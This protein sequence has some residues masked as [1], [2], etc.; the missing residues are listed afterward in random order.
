M[1]NLAEDILVHN[2]KEN[3]TWRFGMHIT[4]DGKYYI[5]TTAKDSS[6]VSGHNLTIQS[7]IDISLQKNLLWVAE[8]KE[9]EVGPN[10]KWNKIKNEFESEFH[11][12]V[13]VPP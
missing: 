6:R 4:D 10:I 2:D 11:V 1:V 13:L 5:L 12:F 3:P 9:N 8:V 7:H